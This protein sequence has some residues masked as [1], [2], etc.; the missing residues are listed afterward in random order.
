MM[1]LTGSPTNWLRKQK[2]KNSITTSSATWFVQL[3]FLPGANTDF[4]YLDLPRC[5]LIKIKFKSES[6]QENKAVCA[7]AKKMYD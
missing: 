7:F 4:K 6:L 1:Q 3:T 2:N 5:I